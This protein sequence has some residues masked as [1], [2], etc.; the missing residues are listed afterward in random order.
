M[1]NDKLQPLSTAQQAQPAPAVFISYA[2]EDQQMA[3]RIFNDLTSV[4]ARPWLDIKNLK[5][6]QRWDNEIKRAISGS[7]YCVVLLSSKSLEKRGFVQKEIRY[8]LS[9]L[10]RVCKSSM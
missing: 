4:G 2:R 10:G 7:N 3:E 9:V 6:G 5:P 8:V 1:N